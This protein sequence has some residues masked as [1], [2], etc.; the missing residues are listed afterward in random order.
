M[1]Q[2]ADEIEISDQ[3]DEIN[4]VQTPEVEIVG[5]FIEI[6]T[7]DPSVEPDEPTSCE[8]ISDQILDSV[9]VTDPSVD[10]DEPIS[11]ENISDQILDSVVPTDL[12]VEQ[13]QPL[14]HVDLSELITEIDVT[15]VACQV[16]I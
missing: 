10:Q 3:E 13:D 14:T 2:P 1:L 9:F 5:S 16:C 7:T 11:C 8:N 6:V 12:S 4:L 15:N